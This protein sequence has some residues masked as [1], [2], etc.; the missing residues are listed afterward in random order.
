MKRLGL[1]TVTVLIALAVV[2]LARSVATTSRQVAADPAPLVPI[3]AQRA[4][5]RLAEAVRF[6]T[7]SHQDRTQFDRAEFIGLRA[8][9]ERAFPRVHQVLGR[10]VINDF[11]L[12]YTWPGREPGRAIV[13]LAHLD[14]VPVEEG[15][16][17]AWSH[18]PFSGAIDDRYV[19][20]RGTLDDKASALAV[21]EAI[22]LL[23]ADGLEPAQT[24]YLAFGHD[25]EV[26][27]E[28]GAVTRDFTHGD[29]TADLGCDP[30]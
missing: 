30:G 9:L 29:C 3:D 4:A 21:L 7:V 22:E 8:F 18:P 12:L 1:L 5:D 16:E 26:N 13:L 11:S 24:V 19:W 25:E 27:G 28:D 2:V 14:V 10:E 17:P 6:R 15:T 23:L 20:G